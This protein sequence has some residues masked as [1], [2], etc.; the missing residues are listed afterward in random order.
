[1]LFG[2]ATMSDSDY[3]YTPDNGHV[4]I[5]TT[6]I[7]TPSI[8]TDK[9]NLGGV[10]VTGVSLDPAD[11]SPME[12]T[13][14]K[15]LNDSVKGVQ[16]QIQKID[17][18]N[19]LFIDNS[20]VTLP[21]INNTVNAEDWEAY[22]WTITENTCV[23]Y[24][25]DKGNNKINYLL[26]KT[27]PFS[28]AGKHYASIDI[29]NLDSGKLEIYNQDN[30]LL[31][32][33][34]VTGTL[35]FEFNIADPSTASLYI[36]ARDVITN[37]FIVIGTINIYFIT[38]RIQD[39]LNYFF[40]HV[41]TGGSSFAS[42]D[43]V[44]R[45]L[46]QLTDTFNDKIAALPDINVLSQ[47]VNH[48]KDTT[49]NVHRVSWQQTGAAALDHKHTLAELG[50]AAVNH[51]H[52][53]TEVGAAAIL[54]THT[55]ASIGAADQYHT[56]TVSE[57]G[58]AP[59]I[60]EHSQYVTKDEFN[61]TGTGSTVP[62]TISK[63]AIIGRNESRMP[64][65]FLSNGVVESPLIESYRLIHTTE[66][67]FDAASGVIFSNT[68]RVGDNQLYKACLFRKYG[69]A[70]TVAAFGNTPSTTSPT[71]I[72]YKLFSRR[73]IRSYTITRSSDVT[74]CGY[75]TSWDVY[76]GDTKIESQ[77]VTWADGE[78]SKTFDITA[79]TTTIRQIT[80]K[81]TSAILVVGKWG[82]HFDLLMEDPAIHPL[83]TILGSGRKATCCNSDGAIQPVAL[84]NEVLTSGTDS[85]NEGDDIWIY[86]QKTD[87]AVT[88]NY[89][90]VP[91]EYGYA[92]K[93][94][95]LFADF[96]TFTNSTRL[97]TVAADN[98]P[99]SG[100]PEDIYNRPYPFEF[101]QDPATEN[102]LISADTTRIITA[103]GTKSITITHDNIP[104]MTLS[105]WQLFNYNK[106]VV[107][108]V[109]PSLVRVAYTRKTINYPTY[110][111]SNQTVPTTDEYGNAVTNGSIDNTTGVLT[112]TATNPDVTI[113]RV[114]TDENNELSFYDDSNSF[115]YRKPITAI[116]K[117]V[118]TFVNN[119]TGD[120]VAISGFQPYFTDDFY[121]ISSNVMYDKIGGNI[122]GRMYLGKCKFFKHADGSLVAIPSSVQSSTHNIVY[123]PISSD[124]DNKTMDIL[125]P[126]FS[127]HIDVQ[128]INN[129]M[130]NYLSGISGSSLT[131]LGVVPT[132]CIK[133]V[134][135]DKIRLI[136]QSGII[137]IQIKRLW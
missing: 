52:T 40:Q 121:D 133:D 44:D 16:R 57:I 56:H 91:P 3:T 10:P 105:S 64:M 126:F 48:M 72:A 118:Y 42:E 50:A 9:L 47:C 115:T 43:Y 69:T 125:N 117:L 97:G 2:D 18:N 59:L 94:S 70:D 46:A 136:L 27:R 35:R 28:R 68:P 51:T 128:V 15:A 109:V 63:M 123:F 119:G 80:F 14:S 1:M 124:T 29:L 49:T 102:A 82:V 37:E 113:D 33:A 13:T 132:V 81:F 101:I 77:T 116:I 106:D 88:Y 107:A 78:F 55:P 104:N 120:H 90:R 131:K 79:Y 54:H 32:T 17:P 6:K 31:A 19:N 96:K 71:T 12:L 92:R 58:A 103:V 98:A 111:T 11:T 65:T 114:Y 73:A 20:V 34:I 60:H 95:P 112:Y 30:E 84:S 76:D 23:T 108:D 21:L 130:Y 24:K 85:F 137:G 135:P 53:A 74:N 62:A 93:G 86:V 100:T 127:T 5:T 36:T 83:V 110:G 87:S 22:L 45:K 38:P 4:V 61:G 75:P 122:S 66:D 25:G 39:Y 41:T 67:V 89:S 134:T 99:A 26:L 8:V 129:N 7:D